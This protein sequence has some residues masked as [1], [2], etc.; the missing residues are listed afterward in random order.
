MGAKEVAAKRVHFTSH[1]LFS[2]AIITSVRATLIS[3]D[4]FLA[5]INLIVGLLCTWHYAGETTMKRTR[6]RPTEII[7]A[8][9]LEV[10]GLMRSNRREKD[11]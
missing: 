5:L 11:M 4:C 1:S 7:R 8:A 6:F 2:F 3:S 10:A 9:S